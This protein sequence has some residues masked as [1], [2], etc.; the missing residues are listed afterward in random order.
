MTG[1]CL[2]DRTAPVDR[3]RPWLAALGVAVALPVA[4]LALYAGFGK[5]QAIESSRAFGTLAG[6]LT[7]AQAPAFRDQLARHLADNPRDARAW[8]LLGRVELALDRFAESEAAFENAVADPK[9]ALDPGIWCDYADAAGLAQG[10][11]LEGKPARLIARALDLDGSHPRALDMAGSL[12][13]EQGHHAN[14]ARHWRSL[15]DQL[16]ATDPRRAELARAVERVERLAVPGMT[17]PGARRNMQVSDP[18]GR[19]S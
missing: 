4:A 8:A 5:P 11:R 9:V 6:P 7:A 18:Q 15:L 3:R 16:G 1:I 2:D 10:G 14:A 12:A 19:G 13:I 17:K